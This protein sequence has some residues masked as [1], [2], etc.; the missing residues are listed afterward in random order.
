MSKE[1][2]RRREAREAAA[3][4][5]IAAHTAHVQ[6]TA[7]RRARR[8]AVRRWLLPL[9]TGRQTG[10]LARRRR[11]RLNLVV[12]VLLFVQVVVWVVR[13]DWQARLAALLVAA[14]AFPVIA[15]FTL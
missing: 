15:L 12:A 7:R 13:P 5:R 14:L 1:R 6:R 3:A 11:A 8:D 2:A 9:T 4:E 10:V